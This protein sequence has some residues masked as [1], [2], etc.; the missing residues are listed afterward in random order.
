MFLV[1]AFLL[2]FTYLL[3]IISLFIYLFYPRISMVL[4]DGVFLAK[5]KF[6]LSI[7][8]QELKKPNVSDLT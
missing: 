3:I 6:Y 7:F 2:L 5:L 8:S 1:C 4:A